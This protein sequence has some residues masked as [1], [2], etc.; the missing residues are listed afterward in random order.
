MWLVAAGA[1]AGMILFGQV[2]WVGVLGGLMLVPIGIRALMRTMRFVSAKWLRQLSVMWN[3]PRPLIAG[4]FARATLDTVVRFDV[5][6]HKNDLYF[7]AF[8]AHGVA[9]HLV[10]LEPQEEPDYRALAAWVAACGWHR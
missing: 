6:R 7:A 10:T 4:Q 9:T 3:V 8:D 1:A 2:P 5:T